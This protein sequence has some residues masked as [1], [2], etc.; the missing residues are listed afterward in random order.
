MCHPEK[1][2]V[3]GSFNV[4]SGDDANPFLSVFFVCVCFVLLCLL[5]YLF[6]RGRGVYL[7]IPDFEPKYE[8]DG[9]YSR[10]KLLCLF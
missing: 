5:V 4:K 8:G 10:H 9:A 3:S 2:N 6:F 7:T 1:L